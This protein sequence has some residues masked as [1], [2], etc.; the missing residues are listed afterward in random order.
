MRIMSSKLKKVTL[1]AIGIIAVVGISIAILF[2]ALTYLVGGGSMSIPKDQPMVDHFYLHQTEFNTLVKMS[3]QDS[4][5]IRI[6]PSFTRLEDNWAWP[7]SEV[8]IGF[9]KERWDEYRKL[10]EKV[11]SDSG[12]YRQKDG[13]VDITAY[14]FG[15]VTGGSEK[16]YAYLPNTPKNLVNSIDDSKSSTESNVPIYRHITGNWYLFYSWDD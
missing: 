7:R 4:K 12:I 5:V 2:V 15:L 1:V 8:E 14:S 11:G 9:S 3:D 10:F 13:S 6:A 16:G